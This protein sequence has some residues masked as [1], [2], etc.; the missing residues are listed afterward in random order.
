MKQL[1]LFAGVAL[2][3][4]GLP[5]GA[6]AQTLATYPV[7]TATVTA[8]VLTTG[9]DTPWELLW[10]PDNFLWMTE[11]GGRI[12]RINPANGQ[13]T[14]V[15]TLADVTETGESGLLG[16]AVGPG[17][18]NTPNAYSVY[19]VYNYTDTGTLKEKLVRFTYANG[20]LGAPQVLLDNIAAQ[21]THSGSRLLLLPDQTLL[22]T[23][24]DAQNQPAA[25]NAASLN[26]KILRLNLDG[27]VP[28]TGN[29]SA[30]SRVYTLG[31]RNPQGLV[32]APSGRIYSS[33]HGPN[34]DDEVNLIEPGRNYGWPNVEGFCNLPAEQT[35]C[36]ANN[37]KEPLVTYT[38]TLAV[39]GLA[40]YTHPAIPGWNN[41]LLMV[42]LKAGKFTQLQLSAAG[43]QVAS[44][45]D[46]WTGTY[47]RLR[48]ICVSPQGKVYLGTS[49]RDGRGTPGA[50]DDRIIVLENRGFTP[51][52]TASAAAKALALWPNPA[53]QTATLHL[54]APAAA[55]AT[56]RVFDALGREVRRAHFAAG[57]TDLVLILNG[58]P[59]GIYRVQALSGAEA[60]A[61]RLAVE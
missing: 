2:A 3:C 5:A 44:Q 27:T 14:A 36:T 25:Q 34:N 13:L 56:A 32:R 10:G 45:S 1:V 38:P 55:A 40:Y 43:T 59:H 54:P 19:V 20:A 58:L 47:G 61:Q 57:Q 11:R 31:H 22:M 28:A 46:L 48:C 8:S 24:G 6:T 49:N 15:A 21:T 30:G 16:M 41:T 23:V 42:S 51:T 60:Y 12:S 7:G 26:G 29:L 35:F 9:L 4:L 18:A 37:V 53:A 17:P 52:A 39:A 50:T 33:E